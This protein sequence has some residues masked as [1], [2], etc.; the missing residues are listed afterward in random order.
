MLYL[1]VDGTDQINEGRCVFFFLLFS[2]RARLSTLLMFNIS[3]TLY[4]STLCYAENGKSIIFQSL[5]C[6]H[7][8]KLSCCVTVSDPRLLKQWW[9]T[10]YCCVGTFKRK[11]KKMQGLHGTSFTVT[12]HSMG[13][14]G[15]MRNITVILCCHCWAV[16]PN[17]WWAFLSFVGFFLFFFVMLHFHT[18]EC[19]YVAFFFFFFFLT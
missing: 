3:F 14:S 4:R 15:L 5:K 17:V 9:R 12:K 1:R 19:F 10:V 16:L 2:N 11:K 18:P 13:S 8:Y 7:L 6:F